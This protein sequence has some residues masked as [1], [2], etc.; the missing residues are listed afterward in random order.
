MATITIELTDEQLAK[1]SEAA[2]MLGL[3]VEEAARLSVV[4]AVVADE[5]FIRTA[6]RVLEKNEALYRRLA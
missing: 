2:R 5:E 6:Q 1:L 4:Q 3:G